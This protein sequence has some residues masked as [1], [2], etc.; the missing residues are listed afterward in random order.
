[1]SELA[2][3]RDR[4]GV[5]IVGSVEVGLLLLAEA[6][7]I[8]R[9]RRLIASGRLGQTFARWLGRELRRLRRFAAREDVAKALEAE[10][11]RAQHGAAA[12]VRTGIAR[13]LRLG[14]VTRP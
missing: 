11:R 1:M 14:R 13:P 4:V 9:R 6:I 7:G 12:G 8:A 5:G 10:L 2:G 3:R